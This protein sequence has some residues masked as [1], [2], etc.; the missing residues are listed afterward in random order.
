MQALIYNKLLPF[1]EEHGWELHFAGPAPWLYSVLTERLN[2]PAERL[3]YTTNVSASLCFSVRKNRHRKG[4]LPHVGYGVLQ[5]L[6]RGLERL[7]RHDSGAYLLRG[8]RHTVREAEQRWDFDLIAGKSPEF[9]VLALAHEVSQQLGKPFLAL[10]DDP[11]GA[12]DEHGFYPTTPEWQQ[13]ILGD[14]RG[15]FFMSPLTKERYVEGAL[16]ERH[17]AHV[18]SDS[19]PV[20]AELYRPG[21]SALA[22]QPEQ[23]GPPLPLRLIYLGMLPEWRPIEP[24]LDA[25]RACAHPPESGP[26]GFQL[27]VYGFVYGAARQR[28]ASDPRLATMI[29]LQPMV[30]YA[31]SHA[32]AQDADVQLVVIGPR[33]LDNVP[34][35]FFEY[36]GHHKPMLILGPLQNPLRPIVQALKI[37]LYVDGR[38]SEAIFAALESLRSHYTSYQQAYTDHA[39]A[40]E[41]FSAPRVA[42][43]FCGLLDQA[44][45][46]EA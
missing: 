35:K 5:L 27:S 37:G 18:I 4:S 30:A 31:E 21:R 36:L 14:C 11:Y 25:L 1:Y 28:I 46:Q 26:P 20:A 34:S 40:I 7:R 45:V 41:A 44:M 42:E 23:D 17:K 22:R 13:A 38:S 33:H 24:F 19:Y 32:L 12:R 39:T 16:V 10:I 43:R 3:H 9:T 2:Y 8:L 15:A 6:A 29:Q